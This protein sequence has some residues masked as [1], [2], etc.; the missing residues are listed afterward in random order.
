MKVGKYKCKP[1]ISRASALPFGCH[2]PG[3]RG[4][5]Y[6]GITCRVPNPAISGTRTGFTVTPSDVE[7]RSGSSNRASAPA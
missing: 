6:E 4:A 2:S 5:P 7:R 3:T 1:P